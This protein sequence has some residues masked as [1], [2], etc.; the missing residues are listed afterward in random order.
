LSNQAS[1]RG[2]C[3][4]GATLRLVVADAA[5]NRGAR[6]RTLRITG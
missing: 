1:R 4:A 3:S 2:V 6:T 5:G